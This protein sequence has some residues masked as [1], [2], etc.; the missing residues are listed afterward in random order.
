MANRALSTW[1]WLSLVLALAWF[2]ALVGRRAVWTIVLFFAFSGLDTVGLL[3]GKILKWWHIEWWA[4]HWSYQS[5]VSHLWWALQIALGGWIVT[6]LTV[7]VVERGH[8]KQDGLFLLGLT[9]LF[10][11]F[12]TIGT[13]VYL[14]WDL[15]RQPIRRALTLQNYSGLMLLLLLGVYF[16]AKFPED[17]VYEP[18]DI[19]FLRQ[20]T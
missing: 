9:P 13:A 1:S 3:F 8:A 12:I 15:V 11:P 18:A 5:A 10:S 4:G 7:D 2:Q 6:S 19:P 16:T 17:R 20:Y 14:A